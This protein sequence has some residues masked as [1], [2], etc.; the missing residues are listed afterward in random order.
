MRPLGRGTSQTQARAQV[1]AAALVLSG[2][3]A[4]PPHVGEGLAVVGLRRALLD[5]VAVAVAW[6]GG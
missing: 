5:G 6:A 1:R 3:A 4:A 2:Q